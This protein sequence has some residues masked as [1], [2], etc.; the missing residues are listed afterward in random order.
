[1]TS[2]RHKLWLGF[3]GLLLILLVVSILSLVVLTRYSHALDRIFHE[4]YDSAVYCDSMK[5][6]LDQLNIRAQRLIWEEPAARQIDVAAP[7]DQ[8]DR[9]LTEQLGNCTLPGE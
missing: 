5:E 6:S 3:G 7:R 1:M 9:S 8:F 4:N 2:L